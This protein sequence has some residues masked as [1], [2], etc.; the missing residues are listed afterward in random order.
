MALRQFF[1]DAR[2]DH[3]RVDD[4]NTRLRRSAQRGRA[5][6]GLDQRALTEEGAGAEVSDDFAVHYCLENAVEQEEHLVT[7]VTLLDKNLA[8]LQLLVPG[9]CALAHQ[10]LRE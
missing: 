3:R 2:L 9:L 7:L 6:P 1:E 4:C 10:L 8:L 5:K